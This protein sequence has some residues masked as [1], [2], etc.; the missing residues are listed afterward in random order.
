MLLSSWQRL[1]VRL[2]ITVIFSPASL[3]ISDI[4]LECLLYVLPALR[5]SDHGGYCEANFCNQPKKKRVIIKSDI[6]LA[7][8]QRDFARR[9]KYNLWDC[10]PRYNFKANYLAIILMKHHYNDSEPGCW[11]MKL[12][13]RNIHRYCQ[14]YHVL[15]GFFLQKVTITFRDMHWTISFKGKCPDIRALMYL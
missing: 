1:E 2:N 10:F 14:E 3:M 13:S 11:R 6:W 5:Q 15:F 7:A 9:R 12:C 4:S 8:K